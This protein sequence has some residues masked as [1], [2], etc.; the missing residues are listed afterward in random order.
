MPKTLRER[1]LDSFNDGPAPDGTEQHS[2]N[3]AEDQ[4]DLLGNVKDYTDN[5]LSAWKDASKSVSRQATL[6]IGFMAVFELL[7]YQGKG[8]QFT[9]GSLSF[10]NTSIVQFALPPIVAYLV[11]DTYLLSVRVSDMVETYEF[12]MQKFASK[13]YAN[14]LDSLIQPIQ[15]SFWTNS[16]DLPRDL[17]RPI[18]KFQDAT[19]NLIAIFV[20][21]L[22]PLGFQIQAFYHLFEIYGFDNPVLWASAGITGI[23]VCFG[24][25]C[26]VMILVE[27]IADD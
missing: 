6:I 24:T 25:V 20:L 27:T 19:T 16:T 9:V 12:L 1:V 15:P 13:I 5:L 14:R 23:L 21:W 10:A 18:N 22:V 2:T 17:N 7:S 3:A 8:G 26:L 11:Y 4:S